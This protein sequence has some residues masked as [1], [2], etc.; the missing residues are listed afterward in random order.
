M[1]KRSPICG[2]GGERLLLSHHVHLSSAHLH[3]RV[4]RAEPLQVARL[5]GVRLRLLAVA[6]T[7]PEGIDDGADQR[8]AG[9]PGARHRPEQIESERRQRS[10]SQCGRIQAVTH[11]EAYDVASEC[12]ERDGSDE[13][14]GA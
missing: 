2:S 6:V 12:I 14:H 4:L 9:D 1:K 7:F 11:A 13:E 5:R 8:D 10:E 3:E